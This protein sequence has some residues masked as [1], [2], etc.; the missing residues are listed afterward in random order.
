MSSSVTT[1]LM[2]AQA[3]LLLPPLV[4]LLVLVFGDEQ[5]A[6][7]EPRE[8]SNESSFACWDRAGADADGGAGG[9]AAAAFCARVR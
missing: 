6:V 2:A 9:V 1:T 5:R 7:P 8:W 3:E 4:P